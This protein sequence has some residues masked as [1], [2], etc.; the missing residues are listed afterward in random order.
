[1]CLLFSWLFELQR[2]ASHTR[3]GGPDKLQLERFVEALSDPSSGLTY[4]ALTGAGKQSVVGAERLFN[5]DLTAFMQQKGYEYEARY[6]EVIW[7]WRRSCDAHGLS[8]LQ[9]CRFNYQFLN[10]I[11]EDLMPWYKQQYDFSLLEV[12]RYVCV[13]SATVRNLSHIILPCC[14]KS[15]TI[16][17]QCL[18][19]KLCLWNHTCIHD[20]FSKETL[21]AVVTNIEGREWRRIEGIKQWQ[22]TWTSKDE[23]YRWCGMLFQCLADT[24]G[25]NFTTKQVRFGF[26]K[27]CVEFKKKKNG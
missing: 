12:N 20:Y 7:N 3:S 19:Q 9:Q 23:Q 10:L 22:A 17:C 4:P 15:L 26:R 8:E 11:L 27:A 5:P 25:C 14:W 21:V 13:L 16:I 24:I 6:T 18:P 2:I 1:M